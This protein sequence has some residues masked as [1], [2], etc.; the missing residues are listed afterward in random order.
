M[1]QKYNTSAYETIFDVMV[2]ISVPI[3]NIIDIVKQND[4]PI[5]IDFFTDKKQ[6]LYEAPQ[7]VII[8]GGQSV[9]VPF[10][11]TQFYTTN[12]SQNIFDVCLMTN[13]DID[14]IMLFISENS[15]KL[16]NINSKIESVLTVNFQYSDIT[17]NKI[18][19]VVKKSN[20]TFSTGDKEGIFDGFLLQENAYYILLE[21]GGNILY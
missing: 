1:S 17:D 3:D 2:S 5:D 11:S 6:I 7:E 16:I 8:K 15:D 14:K 10:N 4:I 20:I 9:T 19:S 12:S 21:E 13:T 18:K